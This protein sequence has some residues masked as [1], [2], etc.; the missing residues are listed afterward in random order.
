MLPLR[1]TFFIL[2]HYYNYQQVMFQRM[3]G[4]RYKQIEDNIQSE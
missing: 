1:A 4:Y 2:G 3:K